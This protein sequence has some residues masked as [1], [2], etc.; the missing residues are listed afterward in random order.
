MLS[1]GL[2][3]ACSKTPD[4]GTGAAKAAADGPAASPAPAAVAVTTEAERLAALAT[5]YHD[6]RCVLVGARFAPDSPYKASGFASAEAFSQAFQKAAT[7]DP[8]WARMAIADSYATPC[9]GKP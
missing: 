2:M 5:T 9:K 7:A 1:M 4:A 8:A 6:L 3:G